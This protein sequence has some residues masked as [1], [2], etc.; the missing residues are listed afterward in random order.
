M[1]G[2]TGDLAENGTRQKILILSGP[3]GLIGADIDK[4]LGVLRFPGGRVLDPPAHLSEEEIAFI[5]GVV[6]LEKRFI[7]IFRSEE[8]LDIGAG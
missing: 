3:R 7:S 2:D 1:R 8:I 5:E 4:I 6:I